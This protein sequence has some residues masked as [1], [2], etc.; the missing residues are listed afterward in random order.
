MI[1]ELIPGATSAHYAVETRDTDA[2]RSIEPMTLLSQDR[3]GETP[4]HYAA[5]NGDLE[6]CQLLVNMNPDIVHIK[7]VDNK[8][9]YDWAVSYNEEYNGS[10]TDVCNFLKTFHL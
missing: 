4:L 10:H 2:L 9:A 8:T 7:D 6:I 5:T 3:D 1:D